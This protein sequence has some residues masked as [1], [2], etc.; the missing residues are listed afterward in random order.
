MN[1][2]EKTGL[3]KLGFVKNLKPNT[4]G[5]NC[6]SVLSKITGQKV[7]LKDINEFI[8]SE[9]CKIEYSDQN[10]NSCT[11]ENALV[12]KFQL[13]RKSKNGDYIYGVFR[14]KD[15]TG[16]FM[17]ITWEIT[18]TPK[19]LGIVNNNSLTNRWAIAECTSEEIEDVFGVKSMEY[20][21]GAGHNKFPDGTVVDEK[22]AKFIRFKT[23]LKNHDGKILYGWFT[24]NIKNDFEGVDWGTEDSF[25]NSRKNR[26]QFFVGRMAFDTIDV[27]N[28]FL[29]KLESK[30][31]EEPW[32]YKNRKDPKFKYPILKSYLEFELDRLYY[33]QEK[34]GWDEK[35][36]YNKDRT[37]ALFNTN[38][39]DKFGH[40]LN[41]MGD[42]QLLGGREIICNLEMCP[43]KL[44]LRKLGFE[45]YEPLPPKFFEDINEIV[46]HC[47]WDIDCNV[48][49]Y[50]HII[51]Q[52]IER[53]PDKYKD[54]EADDLG[55]KM[56][57]AIEFAKKIAQRNY[58]FIIPMY[59]PTAHRIQLLMPIYLETS[60]TSQPD[61]ALVLTPH[62]NERVYTPETILGLDEVY[63][64]A[65]LVAKPEE[66]W[67]NPRI[68][69]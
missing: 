20:L 53:F 48:S 15:T 65:R 60:Y 9:L 29:E 61:F 54:L 25:K 56:D 44:S 32:E 1:T 16:N 7:S 4:N 51:E 36:L 50:E 55:Q 3:M 39:I 27:C 63:Q 33:E 38:L 13:N 24:K 57:N 67:L 47:E 34:Y 62:A 45:N 2:T 43:S 59:Y 40:D 14:R 66:S 8:E 21:N 12:L 68:I 19:S 11:I 37:K 35:I 30:T 69:K 31:I 52:R 26:E 28:T 23:T 17:G 41:I 6:I 5:E 18:K 22:N 49:K 58:K 46:F 10:G 42:V 64:D